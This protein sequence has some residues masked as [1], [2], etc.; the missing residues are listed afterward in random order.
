VPPADENQD[1]SFLSYLC[2]GYE[3][4][5]AR[6]ES[7]DV[8]DGDSKQASIHIERFIFAVG[9]FAYGKLDVAD[10]LLDYLPTSG[11]IRK[12]ALAIKALMPLP[13]KLH[14]LRNPEGTRLWLQTH[15]D[16]LQ[17][18]DEVGVYELFNGN[19]S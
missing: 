5:K 11:G 18:N 15:R 19:E 17:W 16:R 13:E 1:E 10:D 6:S 8:K 14:P 12:L 9:L 2:S 3:E 4:V 7:V